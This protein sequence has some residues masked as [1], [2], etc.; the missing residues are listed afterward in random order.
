MER[1]ATAVLAGGSGNRYTP[2]FATLAVGDTC[3]CTC[4][5]CPAVVFPKKKKKFCSAVCAWMCMGGVLKE[6]VC[7]CICVCTS[8]LCQGV[9]R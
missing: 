6:D 1:G 9:M 3:E 2:F 5:S 4:K 8:V 7:I